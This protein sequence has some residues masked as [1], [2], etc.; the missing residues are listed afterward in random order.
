MSESIGTEGGRMEVE[1]KKGTM[2]FPV[3]QSHTADR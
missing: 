3:L 1:S 2:L